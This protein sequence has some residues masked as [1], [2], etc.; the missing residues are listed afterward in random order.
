MLTPQHK[1]QRMGL[2]LQHLNRYHDEGP[3]FSQV[4][5]LGFTITIPRQ[6]VHQSSGNILRRL[7]AGMR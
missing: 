4:M 5:S 3:E 1:M 6:S 2:A 7:E